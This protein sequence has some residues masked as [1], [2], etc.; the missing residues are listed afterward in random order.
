MLTFDSLLFSSDPVMSSIMDVP[1]GWAKYKA[2]KKARDEA[3]VADEDNEDNAGGG[4]PVLGK[5][6]KAKNRGVGVDNET[7]GEVDDMAEGRESGDEGD[8]N[9]SITKNKNKNNQE[10]EGGQNAGDVRVDDGGWGNVA[11]WLNPFSLGNI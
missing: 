5:G 1:T 3:A 9:G 8:G 4:G 11:F 7:G 2:M 10:R 6:T